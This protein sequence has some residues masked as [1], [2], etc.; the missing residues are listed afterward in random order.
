MSKGPRAHRHTGRCAAEDDRWSF[1]QALLGL[2]AAYWLDDLPDLSCKDS[3]RQ[4]TV[5]GPRLSCKQQVPGSSPRRLPKPVVVASLASLLGFGSPRVGSAQVGLW[6]GAS[7]GRFYPSRAS[8]M[9]V[10]TSGWAR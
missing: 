9:V 8:A 2:T 6:V 7:R 1:R 5:D 3:T 10:A 4:H